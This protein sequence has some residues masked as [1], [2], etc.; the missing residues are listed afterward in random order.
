MRHDGAAFRVGIRAHGTVGFGP[1]AAPAPSSGPTAVAMSVCGGWDRAPTGGASPVGRL[2]SGAAAFCG[3][4]AAWAVTRSVGIGWG[5]VEPSA[6]ATRQT[7]L[8]ASSAMSSAQENGAGIAPRMARAPSPYETTSYSRTYDIEQCQSPSRNTNAYSNKAHFNNRSTWCNTQACWTMRH[9][10]AI[11]R[12]SIPD[13]CRRCRHCRP[14]DDGASAQ[15]PVPRPE[16][17]WW[18]W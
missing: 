17:L 1:C 12:A 14:S 16:A 2:E 3:A 18:D 8:P 11:R 10:P 6:A 9:Q 15:W 7:V 13:P 4:E 5:V